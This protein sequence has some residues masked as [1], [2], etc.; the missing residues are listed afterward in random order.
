MHGAV[1]AGGIGIVAASD[2]AIAADEA[3][4]ALTEVKLAGAA[5]IS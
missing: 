5:I 1:R 2:V 3:T 4:F